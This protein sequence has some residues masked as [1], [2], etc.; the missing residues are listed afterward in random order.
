[1]AHRAIVE[2]QHGVV[3]R[4]PL[5]PAGLQLL[6]LDQWPLEGADESWESNYIRTGMPTSSPGPGTLWT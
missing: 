1:M 4:D 6:V 3:A 5:D 2:R